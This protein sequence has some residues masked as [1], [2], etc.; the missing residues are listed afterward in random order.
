MRKGL[1]SRFRSTHIDSSIDKVDFWKIISAAIFKDMTGIILINTILSKL[2][3]HLTF[4]CYILN[5][6][7]IILEIFDIE[8]L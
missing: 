7:E 3:L 6:I 8:S 5:I 1:I 2:K 4:S